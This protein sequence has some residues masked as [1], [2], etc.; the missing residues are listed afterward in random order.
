MADSAGRVLTQPHEQVHEVV[1]EPC[2]DGAPVASH[3]KLGS[4]SLD[5]GLLEHVLLTASGLR[6]CG[7]AVCK[8]CTATPQTEGV[9]SK[10]SPEKGRAVVTRASAVRETGASHHGV[11]GGN[12]E[13]RV[14]HDAGDDSR[15]SE[16]CGHLGVMPLGPCRPNA[17]VDKQHDRL[18]AWHCCTGAVCF[19]T[20]GCRMHSAQEQVVE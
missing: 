14:L 7:T 20:C 6:Y 19:E 13:E 8:R 18:A 3:F 5:A 12:W 1:K 4:T 2:A 9:V 16:A 17:S 11:G 15:L 10:N